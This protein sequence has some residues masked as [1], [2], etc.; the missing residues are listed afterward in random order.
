[1]KMKQSVL[2]FLLGV[3]FIIGFGTAVLYPETTMGTPITSVPYAISTAGVYYLDSDL[4][5]TGTGN[6]ILVEVSNVVIDLNGH[7][8]VNTVGSSTGAKGI[9]ANQ[10]RNVTIK[11]GTIKNF[12]HAISIDDST[13]YTTTTGH[14]IEGI[15]VD[16]CFY[17]GILVKGQGNIIRNNQIITTGGNPENAS[18]YGICV[19]G[20]GNEVSNNF[21]YNTTAH[22]GGIAVG[23]Y[24]REVDNGVVEFNRI[25]KASGTDS[26]FGISVVMSSSNVLVVN[27]RIAELDTGISYVTS[28]GKYRDNIAVACSTPYSGGTN[29]G[30]NN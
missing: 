24:L 2:F 12:L 10:R 8:L 17:V 13:P 18:A 19:Y 20:P 16:R 26:S 5:Y 15:R 29:I 11:N 27:N 22:N 6:A 14:L 3:I 28:T 7:L 1:M 9:Y 23:I 4:T 21:V 30:N 25:L